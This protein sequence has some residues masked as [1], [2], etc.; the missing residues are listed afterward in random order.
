[1]LPYIGLAAATCHPS[2]RLIGSPGT[3]GRASLS[4]RRLAV[5]ATA[6]LVTPVLLAVRWSTGQELAVPLIVAGTIVSFLLVV[7]RMSG[8]VAEL[9]S[10]RSALE[11]EAAHDMLTGLPNRQEFNRRLIRALASGAAGALLFVDLDHFK[12]IND[13]YG[14]QAGDDVLIEVARRL[15]LVVR[16]G[17]V[18]GR[19]AGDEFVVLTDAADETAVLLMAERLLRE[20][21]MIHTSVNGALRVTASIGVVLWPRGTDPSDAAELLNEA[22]RAMYAAKL[23]CGNQLAVRSC[24]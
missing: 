14:H 17:D 4:R 1:M 13:T 8:L 18:A 6:A 12:E 15:R 23:A 20:I 5:L 10:S 9:E 21:E 19:L 16:V 24:A 3:P 7:A 22:D 11:F 2:I